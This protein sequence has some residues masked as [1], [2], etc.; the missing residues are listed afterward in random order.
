ML[1][2]RTPHALAI[3]WLCLSL[4]WLAFGKVASAQEP[5]RRL[6]DNIGH[7]HHHV[8]HNPPHPVT[9]DPNRFLT[10]REAATLPLPEERDAFTFAVFGDRTGGPSEGVAVLAEAVHDVNLI[11]P[12][13]V[14]TV[15]DLIEG[16][17]TT[18][19]WLQQMSEFK[20]IMG[21]LLCPWFPVAG[22]HDVY[23]RGPNKPAGEHERSYELH[24]GPLWYAFEHKDC[25]FVVLYTDEGNPET[26][27]KNFRKPE[28]MRMSDEQLSWLETTLEKAKDAE[29]VFVFVHHPR[30]LGGNYGDD[31]DRVHERLLAAGNVS[32]VFAGHIH[33]MRYDPRDGIEYVTLATVGG[34]QS[35]HVPE[36]GW[37]H[38]FHLVTVRD[39]A[40]AL[41]AVPVGQ[42]MDVR[43]LTG[44]L[45]TETRELARRDP[46]VEG[47]IRLQSDGAATGS[48][49]ARFENP[50]SRPIE[51]VV[52]GASDD[53]RWVFW[54]D[55]A[56]EILA[57]GA[58]MEVA[59]AARRPAGSADLAYR[60]P[61][62]SVRADYLARG[63]RYAIPERTTEIP[64]SL[65]AR[66]LAE[67]A[68]D[69]TLDVD[70]AGAHAR[71]DAS[72]LRLPD[73]PL[74][75][76]CRFRARSFGRRVGL[77]AKTESSEYGIFV[78]NGRPELSILLG[79]GYVNAALP[80]ETAPLSTDRW[81]HIA[82]VYDGSEVRLYIDGKLVA[83]T[84]GSGPRRTNELP[85][86]I[87]ADVDGRGRAMS[88]FDGEVDDVRI[89][90][91]ARY[92]GD[93]FPVPAELPAADD[94]TH[95]LLDMTPVLGT[96]L[97]DRSSHEAHA[98]LR[99]GA[100][101]RN[102]SAAR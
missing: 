64:V 27:E 62:L 89:S 65:D 29:H 90:S 2:R 87:G 75:L 68:G 53:S 41:S 83:R 80:P 7:E 4:S 32:A 28:C 98:S 99:A 1:P 37:L 102:A 48:V 20:G 58:S 91:S 47:E 40:I 57:P 76:E 92:S 70:G 46:S 11:E 74:T 51:V 9:L 14:M 97:L 101:A 94:S 54:P 42:V 56:H 34:G 25:W 12:D 17:N 67:P 38:E 3:P 8:R 93:A 81:Y 100:R 66:A 69:W 73:G 10:N 72:D 49:L 5:P 43:E 15:G 84:E 50:T 71:V 78:S 96:W 82:G 21:K 30:W 23:W 88:F 44:D 36:S 79:D 13:F 61:R 31:W 85:F 60:M 19:E 6:A 18:V 86:F 26:G 45:V 33:Q 22:N 59:L 35:G 55:H 52:R 77:I 95:L 39:D 63:R 24:F 16:Y